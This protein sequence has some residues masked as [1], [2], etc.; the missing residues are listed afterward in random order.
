MCGPSALKDV[1][2]LKTTNVH[3]MVALKE[4]LPLGIT[5]LGMIQPLGTMNVF[6]RLHGNPI[7]E[8]LTYFHPDPKWQ[9]HSSLGFFASSPLHGNKLRLL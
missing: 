8:L 1:T 7:A 2:S 5:V 9:L 6:T 3:L 4:K